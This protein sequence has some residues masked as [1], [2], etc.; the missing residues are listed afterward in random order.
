[1]RE[2]WHRHREKTTH[3]TAKS[4]F[5]D[6]FFFLM[7]VMDRRPEGHFTVSVVSQVYQALGCH[8]KWTE[9][10]GILPISHMDWCARFNQSWAELSH[11]GVRVETKLLMT[12]SRDS[13]RPWSLSSAWCKYTGSV[14]RFSHHVRTIQQFQIR[15]QSL[16][17]SFRPR[18]HCR[19]PSAHLPVSGFIPLKE[20]NRKGKKRGK[21]G[22]E[23]TGNG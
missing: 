22:K 8:K 15:S 12:T 10:L 11:W 16:P 9:T 4:R 6:M 3:W 21:R 5:Y 7:V 2:N 17:I 1:M 14:H 19:S 13:I 20:R 18:E 23:Q